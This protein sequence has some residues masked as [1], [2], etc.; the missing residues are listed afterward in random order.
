MQV[1]AL[2][3]VYD[4]GGLCLCFS[5]SGVKRRFN[6]FWNDFFVTEFWLFS[7]WKAN[8][9]VPDQKVDGV[10]LLLETSMPQVYIRLLLV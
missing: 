2:L 3:R 7:D 5:L 9:R 8:D 4:C 6:G 10:I 1:W